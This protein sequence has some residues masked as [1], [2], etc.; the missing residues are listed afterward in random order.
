MINMARVASCN[1]CGAKFKVPETTQ[2]A[3]AKC[4]KC[5]G[6]V[7]IPPA[8]GSSAP[9]AAAPSAPAPQAPKAPAKAPAPAA[10]KAPAPRTARA[11]ASPAKA[12]ATGAGRSKAGAGTSKGAAR[13]AK[14]GG[15]RS[16][17]RSGGKRG[18]ATKDKS[19]NAG[20]LVGAVVLVAVA[21][22]AAW[23]FGFRDDGSATP[24]DT[25]AMNGEAST[26]APAGSVPEGTEDISDAITPPAG[27]D[28]SG[29]DV[30]DAS[31]AESTSAADSADGDA[32]GTGALDA[33][34]ALTSPTAQ[35]PA[36]TDVAQ[37]PPAAEQGKVDPD[38]PLDTL[39]MFDPFGPIEG[40]T[41]QDLEDWTVMLKELYIEDGGATGRTRKRLRAQAAELD[42]IELTPA[43]LNAIIGVDLKETE[44]ILGV[45]TMV[46]DWQERVGFVPTFFF[47]GDVNATEII[48]QNKRV[49]V[50]D[51]WHGWWS[52]YASGKG[53]LVAYREKM[54]A[55]VKARAR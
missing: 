13:K 16:S 30:A 2:A 6:V 41:E 40:A 28:P 12:P 17:S 49:K 15:G 25:T 31:P 43:F 55:A 1:D 45:F 23:W 53:D 9:A 44:S 4:P 27:S 14:A 46:K 22:G 33:L 11:K 18:K 39:I 52:G 5:G 3:R 10:N 7:A 47:D 51:L 54:E 19:S 24:A 38:E 48:D 8:E 35:A 20:M 26:A 29:D 36:A 32:G 42:I 50:V 34:T 37:A 21:A